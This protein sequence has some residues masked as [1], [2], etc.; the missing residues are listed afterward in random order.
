MSNDV[1]GKVGSEGRRKHDGGVR[2]M[3]SRKKQA[4]TIALVLF[5]F[6]LVVRPWLYTYVIWPPLAMPQTWEGTL[7]K[8]YE[9][10]YG[11][12]GR[13]TYHWRVRCTDG[14]TRTCDVP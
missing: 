12:Y 2:M 10:R 5:T 4:L 8:K 6:L 13:R 14:K 7:I 1:Q 3:A 9:K 11:P